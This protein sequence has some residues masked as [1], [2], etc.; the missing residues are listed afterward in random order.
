MLRSRGLHRCG[1]VEVR[2]E[3]A[4]L[5]RQGRV[6]QGQRRPRLGERVAREVQSTCGTGNLA[7]VGD[8]LAELAS[9]GAEQLGRHHG[10]GEVETLLVG[11]LR[12]DGGLE[13][14]L[15]AQGD[16]GHVTGGGV[17]ELL[18]G[19]LNV[20]ELLPTVAAPRRHRLDV[21]GAP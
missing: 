2:A 20:P 1:V 7:P 18:L 3:D 9:E 6:G 4:L 12:Q 14:R 11:V 5:A 15:D 17:L 10:E 13:G 16:E 21:D 8:A 19:L